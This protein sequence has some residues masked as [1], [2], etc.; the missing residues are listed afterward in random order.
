MVFVLTVLTDDDGNL[1]ADTAMKNK[2]LHR[3]IFNRVCHILARNLPGAT[4]LRPFLHRL[5]GVQI[6]GKVFIGDDVYI[7][8]EYPENVEI[9]D[10]AQISLR[11]TIIAHFRG[12]GRIVIGKNACVG[13]CCSI[14]ASPEKTT[15]IGE[16]AVV[17]MHSC[18]ISSIPAYTFAFG[19]PAK[20][21]YRT[22][23]PMTISTRYSKWRQGLG[24]LE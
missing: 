19:S 3:R 22:K 2:P 7:E 18:V 6:T 1:T 16:A 10:G 11:T 12:N 5:R 4:T 23:I 8:N 13:M 17:G 9:H 14:A 21:A 20:P 15:V 24:P